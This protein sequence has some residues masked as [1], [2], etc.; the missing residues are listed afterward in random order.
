MRDFT[1]PGRSPVHGLNGAAATSHPI[2]TLAAINVLQAGGNAM[3]AAVTACAVQC[4]VEPASTGIGGDCFALYAPRGSDRIVAY[5]GSGRAPRAA[6]AAW[7]AEQG[8]EAIE[9]HTP[10][11]VTVP[12]AV[13]AWA[14]LL[15]DHG[16]RSLADALG[17][18]I[19]YAR[20]GYA[21]SGRIASDFAREAATIERDPT[22]ARIFLP[23]G[24]PPSVGSVHRQPQLAATLE[25]IAEGGRDA[26]Y[27]GP[28]AEDMVGY[29][30]SLGGLHTM[31][32]F[33]TAAGEYVDPVT[34]TYKGYTVYECPPNGQGIIALEILNIFSHLD[35]AA[36]APLSVE[37]L[38]LEIEAQRLAYRDRALYVA[39]PRHAAVPMDKL[40]SVGRAG[41]LAN[42]I[43]MNRALVG[44]PDVDA[45]PA[46][47][48]TIYLCVVDKDRNAVSF[49][50]SLFN[51]FGSGLCAPKSGVM[52]QNR[53]MAFALDPDHANC[54]APGKRP[55]HT[56][57]PGML[58][59]DGHAV[60]PFGVMG[61]AYQ[62]LGHARL[63]LNLLEYGLDIQ[64]AIDMP[65]V[66]ASAG[67]VIEAEPSLP[68]TMVAGL[69][70]KGHIM[71]AVEKPHGGG[72]AIWI[73]W[74][75]GVLTGGSEPRKDGCALGY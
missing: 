15:A 14:R 26:F 8:I 64:E 34:T 46:H 52:L 18:A 11:S 73:D 42:A 10:H 48:D 53:G 33:E 22:A 54:I 39:D 2:A 62:A 23:G 71:G 16:T 21:I 67:G 61:G 41:E 68:E 60:M 55:F 35:L 69:A 13:D 75:Q 40:L 44:L 59:R 25:R 17:P 36:H 9:R 51:G 65:R 70:A 31:E 6:T 49:I 57:I 43:S 4:V 1:F 20:D 12:G 66:F 56:I 19:R 74:E 28:V 45:M 63:L 72:Q 7:Y 32:D 37:R 47:A 24:K 27:R 3:D 29:L 30:R 50:N 58:A 5:N 38:H